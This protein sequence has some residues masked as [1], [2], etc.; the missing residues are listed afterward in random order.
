M[1][2]KTMT[3][4]ALALLA[5]AAFG[6]TAMPVKSAAPNAG[7]VAV[8]RGE[9]KRDK[10]DLAAKR[11]S[12]HSALVQLDAQMKAELAKI[13]AGT[14][15]R[16]EKSAARKAV[17]AKYAGLRKDARAKAAFERKNLREDIAGKKALI[18]KMRRS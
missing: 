12:Q 16:A 15:T 8:L 6:Q 3:V 10:G 13:K 2:M 14:G 7:Q 5:P 4:L 18:L 11:Q 9:I 17:K 1:T